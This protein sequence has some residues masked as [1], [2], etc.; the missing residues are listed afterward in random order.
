V[1]FLR[2]MGRRRKITLLAITCLLVIAVLAWLNRPRDEPARATVEDAVRSFR[3]ED[4]SGGQGGGSEEPALGV[5]R[6][7]TQGSEAVKTAFIGATHDYDG[8]STIVLSAGRCGERE[9]WQVL[10]GRWSEAEACE[11]PAGEASATV[12]EFHEFFGQGQEDLLRC[13]SSPVSEK[14]GARF[15]SSCRSEDFS[16]SNRSRVVEVEPVSVGGETF[17][18]TH[19]ETRSVFGG[20]N[21]GTAER[22]EWRRRSDGLLLRRSAESDADT[23]AGGGSHYSESYT[24]R[25]LSV[26]PKR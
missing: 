10:S 8:T 22:D 26:T 3:A 2:G 5:Y 9:R 17:D 23:S 24:I 15:A 1:G 21:S 6:Y 4:D 12:I 14:P 20:E 19:V 25:L 13:D 7:A 16:I 18:A 11:S